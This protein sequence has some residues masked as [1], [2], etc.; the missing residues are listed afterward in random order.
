MKIKL[1]YLTLVLM[2]VLLHA[3]QNPQLGATLQNINSFNSPTNWFVDIMKS[4]KP[5]SP[6]GAPW[7]PGK[8]ALDPQGW[9]TEPFSVWVKHRVY[10]GDEGMYNLSFE[11]NASLYIEDT[12]NQIL[13]KIY[14]PITN[15]TT[16]TIFISSSSS[17]LILFFETL[18]SPSIQH[19]IN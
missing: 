15:K 2:N 9:P 5:F 6:V 7:L 12:T 8:P 13:N 1:L 4:A 10:P 18:M 17:Q 14:D 3:Q 19:Q 11:G 16:A